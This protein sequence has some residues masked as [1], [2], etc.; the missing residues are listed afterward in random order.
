MKVKRVSRETIAFFKEMYENDRLFLRLT[1]RTYLGKKKG[2]PYAKVY[3]LRE[4]ELRRMA[5][6]SMEVMLTDKEWLCLCRPAR[7]D[8][9][10]YLMRTEEDKAGSYL[11]Y[12]AVLNEEGL[13]SDCKVY[14]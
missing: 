2:D 6:R 1:N 12:F 14:A 3:I 10:D 9:L 11:K 8:D 5:T 13:L 4:W 7:Q